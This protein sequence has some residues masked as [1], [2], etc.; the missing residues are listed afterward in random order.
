MAGSKKGVIYDLD[1]TIIVT[2]DLHDKGWIEAGRCLN[3]DI[4]QEFLI[5]QKGMPEEAA[6]KHLLGE[7]FVEHGENLIRIKQTYTIENCFTAQF[8]EDFLE[9]FKQLT[10]KDIKAWICTSAPKGFVLAVFKNLTQLR[11]LES[12]TVFREMYKLG[13]PNPEPII[14]TAKLMGL[15]VQNCIYVGDAHNDYLAATAAGAGFAY[16]CRDPRDRDI[17]IPASIPIISNHTQILSL[18]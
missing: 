8:Y 14:L 7:K 12:R 2:T 16:A 13:K 3:V 6:A 15:D 11:D 4:P 17:R 9:A 10:E 5:H 18:I 1:G